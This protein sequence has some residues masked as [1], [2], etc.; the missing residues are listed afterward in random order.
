MS[1]FNKLME[2]FSAATGVDTVVDG[3]RS[4]TLE[5]DGMLVTLQ[6]LED[7]DEVVLFAPAWPSSTWRPESRQRWPRLLRTVRMESRKKKGRLTG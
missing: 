6:Y 5:A 2:E 1:A 3:E 7:A 4:C